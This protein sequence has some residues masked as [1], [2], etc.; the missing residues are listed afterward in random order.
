MNDIHF[1]KRVSGPA[2]NGSK[3][4]VGI[5]AIKLKGVPEDIPGLREYLGE[6]SALSCLLRGVTLEFQGFIRGWL[7]QK[8]RNLTPEE[9]ESLPRFESKRSGWVVD[10]GKYRNELDAALSEWQP[11]QRIR[12][13][14]GQMMSAVKQQNEELAA[15]MAA[16]TA[17][18]S[19]LLEAQQQ[20]K[21]TEKATKP[22]TTKAY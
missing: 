13:N 22:K 4:Q 14:G 17:Q 20:A 5:E 2:A 12:R 7:S 15:Q 6:D 1:F 3:V 19:K 9:K 21:T 18:L 8:Y 16:V 10:L 11:G